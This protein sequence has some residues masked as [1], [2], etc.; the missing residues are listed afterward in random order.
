[1]TST[2]DNKKKLPCKCEIC[3]TGDCHKF[4]VRS[5]LEYLLCFECGHCC[6]IHNEESLLSKFKIAQKKYYFD[7]IISQIDY[8]SKFEAEVL[9]HR[10]FT[11]QRLVS[12]FDNVLEVGPGGGHVS[13]L[14]LNQVKSVT[15]IEHSSSLASHLAQIGGL[16]I[17]VG[18]FEL[19]T[20][21]LNYYDLVCSF[22][23][24]EH[25]IDPLAHLEKSLS[26]VRPGGYMVIA[27][28][29]SKSLEQLAFPKLSPNFDSAHLRVFSPMSLRSLSKQ[30]GWDVVSVETPEFS[31]DWFRVLSKALRRLRREDEEDTA[32]KYSQSK[33]TILAI[34][35]RL[36]RTCFLPFRYLQSRIGYGNEILLVL[37]KPN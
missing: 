36:M 34:F 24:I 23:V 37:Q 31:I 2:T 35:L 1:M 33:S 13:K 32:G 17:L 9:K 20:V 14:L 10:M 3:G 6:Q 27:T 5:Q 18:E 28:P 4:T 15:V 29:N 12:A 26:I 21:Q 30:A 16:K 19:L 8:I 22:H 25:V 7:K 11:I